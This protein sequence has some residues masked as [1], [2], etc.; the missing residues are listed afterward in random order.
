MR[1][2]I[3]DAALS[4]LLSIAGYI[5]RDN[6]VRAASFANELREACRSLATAPEAYPLLAERPERGIRR[7]PHQNYLIFYRA[8]PSQ[9]EILHVLHARRNVEKIL[10]PD[11]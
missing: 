4:D 2:V 11:P 9:V 8:M 5:R 3:T 7:K 10:F 6:P 1:V